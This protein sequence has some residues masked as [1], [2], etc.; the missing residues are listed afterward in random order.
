VRQKRRPPASHLLII[1]CEPD[2]LG[3]Q[4]LD[5]G[6]RIN[7]LLSLPFPKKKIVLVK[8]SSRD[9]LCRALGETLEKHDRFRSILVV[10]HSNEKGLQ[11]TPREFYNWKAVGEWLKPF[12][13]EFLLVAACSAGRST[14]I[15]QLFERIRTLREIYASPVTLFRD[16]TH[17]FALLLGAVVRD[18]KINE[19]FLRTLQ[20]TGYLFTDAVIYQFKRKET[21]DGNELERLGWDLLGQILNRRQQVIP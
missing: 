20:V 5:F 13:P 11:L 17:P 3:Q 10:G 19:R 16:Q 14:G 1:E 2:K 4:Q 7:A 18:R 12:Q 21:R 9:E 8:A 15:R 6:T